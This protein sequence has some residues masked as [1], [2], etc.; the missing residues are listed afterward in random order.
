MLRPTSLESTT[1]I[2]L[3]SIIGSGLSFPKGF[4][5]SIKS[6]SSE[7]NKE[8]EISQSMVIIGGLVSCDWVERMFLI[9][10]DFKA[11]RS[12]IGTEKPPAA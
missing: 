9:I 2:F 7:L 1:R 12:V 4:R 8:G 10:S 6:K 5:E 11:D 3:V